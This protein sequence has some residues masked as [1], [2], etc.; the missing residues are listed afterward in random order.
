MEIPL[1][2][3]NVEAHPFLNDLA[4]MTLEEE[5]LFHKLLAPEADISKGRRIE[6][7]LFKKFSNKLIHRAV[8]Q[9][10]QHTLL[11]SQQF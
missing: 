9:L 3:L 4:Q 7:S 1:A 11:S 6:L 8:V 5:K 10:E 2:Q